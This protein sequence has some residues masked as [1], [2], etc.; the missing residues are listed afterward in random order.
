MLL[1]VVIV[2]DIETARAALNFA[3]DSISSIYV[4]ADEPGRSTRPSAPR[5]RRP[6]PASTPAA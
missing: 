3:K 4:E 2:M 1:D 6:T 5:S